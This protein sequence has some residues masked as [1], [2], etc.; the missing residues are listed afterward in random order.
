MY[1]LIAGMLAELNWLTVQKIIK[2]ENMVFLYKISRN[3]MPDI[4]S[5]SNKASG[6][7]YK[8]QLQKFLFYDGLHLSNN[9]SGSVQACTI[10]VFLR[11]K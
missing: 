11:S 6:Y 1:A 4:C 3:L 10:F 7:V 8:N 2:K 5:F 9:F